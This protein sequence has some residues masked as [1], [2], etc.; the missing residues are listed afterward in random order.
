MKQ[1]NL[2]EENGFSE[3][4]AAGQHDLTPSN[5][6][7]KRRWLQR[8]VPDT[9]WEDAKKL[10]VL[11]GPLVRTLGGERFPPPPHS[12][13]WPAL[14]TSISDLR[15]SSSLLLDP[16]P[17]ADLP[18]TPCQ[19]HILW[20]PG[21]GRAGLRHAGYRCKHSRGLPWHQFSPA[22]TGMV[23]GNGGRQGQR[24]FQT[25]AFPFSTSPYQK[26]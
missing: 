11:A 19:L 20:P 23:Y 8:L 21:Q 1:A 26:S 3:A 2:P 22:D 4:M 7:K 15:L 17:A 5:C 9:F 25:L 24:R 12:P 6:R 16:D 10:L 18:D 13:A 14:L